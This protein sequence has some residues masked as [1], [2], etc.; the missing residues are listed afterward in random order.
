MF[1]FKLFSLLSRFRQRLGSWSIPE[2]SQIVHNIH[3]R[4]LIG[5]WAISFLKVSFRFREFSLPK[6]LKFC[7]IPLTALVHLRWK[8]ENNHFRAIYFKLFFILILNVDTFI[9]RDFDQIECLLRHPISIF[10][11]LVW[12]WGIFNFHMDIVMQRTQYLITK[13]GSFKDLCWK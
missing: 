2:L 3:K 1:N 9:L 8:I 4:R 7:K 11:V 6:Y 10:I 5:R 12:L 13:K